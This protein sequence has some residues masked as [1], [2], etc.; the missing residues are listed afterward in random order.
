MRR[1]MIIVTFSLIFSV[2]KTAYK[3]ACMGDWLMGTLSQCECA[4]PFGR[5]NVSVSTMCLCG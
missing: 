5:G 1:I 4:C 3:R 2:T